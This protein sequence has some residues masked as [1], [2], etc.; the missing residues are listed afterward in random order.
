M[1]GITRQRL[2]VI[3][4]QGRIGHQVAGRY[5]IFTPE[6]VEAFKPQIQGK[7]GRPKNDLSPTMKYEAPALAAH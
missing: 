1:L 4:Q 2:A 6:E 3:A 5:W 7:A